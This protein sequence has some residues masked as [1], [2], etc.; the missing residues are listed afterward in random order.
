MGPLKKVGSD[1]YCDHK[2]CLTKTK[3]SFPLNYIF[4][5]RKKSFSSE[6]LC[7]DAANAPY[8]YCW[9]ILKTKHNMSRC[10]QERRLN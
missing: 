6:K 3:C 5:P 10:S 2:G 8:I 9:G 7:K 4:F 1:D